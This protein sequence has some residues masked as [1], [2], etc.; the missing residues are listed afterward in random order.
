MGRPLSKH[1]KEQNRLEKEAAEKVSLAYIYLEDGAPSTAAKKLREGADLLDKAA[2][3]RQ[4]A[5]TAARGAT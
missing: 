3:A 4:K 5:L 1:L 2:E